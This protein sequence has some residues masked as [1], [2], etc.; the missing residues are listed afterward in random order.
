MIFVSWQSSGDDAIGDGDSYE[1][2]LEG[3]SG[4]AGIQ[5]PLNVVHGDYTLTSAP[6][7]LMQL[8]DPP[9]VNDTFQI[10]QGVT[11]L[12]PK[13]AASEGRRF[14]IVNVWRNIREEPIQK[15]AQT[16]HTASRAGHLSLLGVKESSIDG[17]F[18]GIR[19]LL[20]TQRR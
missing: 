8:T 3:G 1:T 20:P 14:M 19:W 2:R 6:T 17:I 7:R 10:T 15:C 4:T 16:S 13:H 18:A 9:K 5:R 11:P 12:L